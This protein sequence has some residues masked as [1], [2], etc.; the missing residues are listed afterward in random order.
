VRVTDVIPRGRCYAS[1]F[2]CSAPGEDE[3][4]LFEALARLARIEARV[5]GREAVD[6]ITLQIRIEDR[7]ETIAF[8]RQ[9]YLVPPTAMLA[10]LNRELE[11]AGRDHRLV[12]CRDDLTESVVLASPTEI[13]ALKQLL[14]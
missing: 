6:A 12:T 8:A 14:I 9:K 7:L 2:K 1:D 13:A 11:R 3:Q 5:V 4:A 10:L